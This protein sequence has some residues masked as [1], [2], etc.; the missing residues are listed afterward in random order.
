MVYLPDEPTGPFD[1]SVKE[2]EA[3]LKTFPGSSVGPSGLRPCHL[4]ELDRSD[5]RPRL[6]EDLAS[7]CSALANNSLSMHA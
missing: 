4:L 3:V 5:E 2:V 1:F 6:L 7:F